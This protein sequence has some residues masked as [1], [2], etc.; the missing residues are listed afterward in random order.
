MVYFY[1]KIS[2]RVHMIGG[3]FIHGTFDKSSGQATG[4][5]LA[6]IYPDMETAFY[7]TFDN[8]VMKN[9][10]EAEVISLHCQDGLMAVKE[11]DVKSDGPTF[12][13]EPPTN[14][15]FGAG[16]VGVIDPYERKW[17]K[18]QASGIPNSGQGVFVTRD[19][20]ANRTISLFSG[21]L[22][23][24]DEEKLLYQLSCKLNGSR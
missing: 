9:A 22:Y 17:L 14:Q 16:P 15:S 3:G 20:P 8:F 4:D 5:N 2:Q 10:K 1:L 6:Y 7:G 18:L 19:V 21:F 13:Y 12:Y 23:R 11:F 24:T